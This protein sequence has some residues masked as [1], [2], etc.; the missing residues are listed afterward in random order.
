ML[1]A[2]GCDVDSVLDE[3][4]NGAEAFRGAALAAGQ[5]DDE[6]AAFESGDGAGEPCEF[7]LRGADG[8]HGFGEAGGFAVDDAA[9]GLRRAV[10]GTEASAADGEDEG[11]VICGPFFEPG[12]DSVFV[13]GEERGFELTLRELQAQ[14]FCNGGAGGVCHEAGRAAVGDG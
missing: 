4:E 3:G 13:V 10:A 9:R 12:C 5:V 1:L 6:R 8:A 14:D 7:V 2:A 11:G